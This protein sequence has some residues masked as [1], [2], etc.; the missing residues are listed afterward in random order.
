MSDLP[1]EG[2]GGDGFDGVDSVSSG[3]DGEHE[4]ADADKGGIRSNDWIFSVRPGHGS[5]YRG[6]N[7][8]QIVV[9]R[10][11]NSPQRSPRCPQHIKI[12]TILTQNQNIHNINPESKYSKPRNILFV[13]IAQYIIF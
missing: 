3:D 8:V 11:A 13:D 4:A 9:Q 12:L 2:D 6:A 5:W 10:A 7:L 1:D